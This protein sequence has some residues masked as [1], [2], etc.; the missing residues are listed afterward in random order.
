MPNP[1]FQ[2]YLLENGK[3]TQCAGIINELGEIIGTRNPLSVKN[4]NIVALEDIDI[5][6]SDIGN[7]TGNLENLF[8]GENGGLVNDD[9]EENPKRLDII[10]KTAIISVAIG[11]DAIE[12]NFSNVE[13][14]KLLASGAETIVNESNIDAD[15]QSRE[16]SYNGTGFGGIRLLFH[17][18]HTVTI[19]N[20]IITRALT[21]ISQNLGIELGADEYFA[22][23]VLNGE[24][25]NMN[26]DGS[27]ESVNFD[28]T[29]PSNKIV[30]LRRSFVELTDGQ[31]D[32]IS[33]NFGAIG[34]LEKGVDIKL[35]KADSTEFVI[36]N[37]KTN[38]DI[39][40]TMFDFY[41]PFK[42][43]AYVGRWTFA[44]DVGGFITLKPGEKVRFTINDDLTGL[45]SFTFD[46]KGRKRNY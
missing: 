24:N 37:W 32:F 6:A 21:V 13:I 2:Y 8:N 17:T 28:Y 20:A 15:R 27:G 40:K 29:V 22:G 46:L 23:K 12:G 18:T 16:Y 39:S 31:T 11:L 1:K 3:W 42:D 26:V 36:R 35:V 10:F 44:R 14:Q 41:N 38:I 30:D 25:D 34:P 5:E 45:D 33:S 4:E 7:F 43:G 9:S 19:T